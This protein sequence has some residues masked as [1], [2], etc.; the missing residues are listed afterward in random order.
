MREAGNQAIRIAAH[1]GVYNAFE[2]TTHRSLL[3]LG[4]ARHR[5]VSSPRSVEAPHRRSGRMRILSRRAWFAA[6]GTAAAVAASG[7]AS[8]QDAA[9]AFPSRPIRIVVPFTPGGGVDIT[10]RVLAEP[11]RAALG[12]GQPV[13]VDNRAGA[14][15]QIG[16]QAVA[17]APPDGYTL[18]LSSA[19]E[20]SIAP[21]L[22]GARLPYD[23]ARELV[24]ITLA[25]RVPNVLV[26]GP[27]VPARNVEELIALARANPGGLTYSS[28][29]A[30]NLQHMN[31]ALLDRLA[32][33]SMVHVPY[34]GTAPAMA[35]VAG[36]RVSMTYAGAAAMLPLIREGKLRAIGVTG[37]RRLASLPDVP[38]LSEYPR[39]ADYELENWYA[40]FAP[41]GTPAPVLERLHA[42]AVT[43][44]RDPDVARRLAEQGSEPAPMEM[45]EFAAFVARETEKFARIVREAGIT[46]EN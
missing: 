10:A 14:A 41:A 32:G 31:G 2:G 34:R 20:V 11:M 40:L 46:V 45:R 27:H 4:T 18:L 35:D 29:G 42:A 7:A 26:I 24:P 12:G 43:A 36:G 8:A 6:A 39:L 28:A 33:V 19:G 13:V 15:G 25:V 37:R 3:R 9:G 44:L 23:P 1:P 16:A 21:A 17:K 30:G 22:F 5:V 38:A